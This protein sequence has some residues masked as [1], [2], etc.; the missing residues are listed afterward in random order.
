[1]PSPRHA[2]I[3]VDSRLC[4]ACG[5]CCNGVL[6]RDVELQ[7][8]DQ[9]TR[10]E[11]LGLALTTKRNT[12][13]FQQP[14]VCLEGKLCRIYDERP[15]RCR[16]F[17]CRLLQREASGELTFETASALI[18]RTRQQ[19]EQVLKLLRQSGQR[20]EH[21]PLS[22]RYAKVMRQ[23]ID[24]AHDEEKIESRAKLMLAVEGLMQVLHREFLV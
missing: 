6:F 3:E 8:S 12:L 18:A 17:E 24:L 22:R 11:A 19:V 21:L 23:P 16:T 14:C 10:L 1:M 2:K 4:A 5:L 7:P 13:R 20:D 9:A 15:T